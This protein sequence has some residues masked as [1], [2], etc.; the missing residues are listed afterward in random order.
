VLFVASNFL[1]FIVWSHFVITLDHILS[2][3]LSKICA[4]DCMSSDKQVTFARIRDM[5]LL[6]NISLAND[7]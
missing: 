6:V 2:S 7:K 4:Y 3:V 5:N 1:V